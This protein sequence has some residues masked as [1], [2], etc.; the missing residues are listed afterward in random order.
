MCRGERK[1]VTGVCCGCEG[2]RMGAGEEE[3]KGCDM[4]MGVDEC[5]RGNEWRCSEYKWLN[6]DAGGRN[7]KE[8]VLDGV[9]GEMDV[10]G[11]VWMGG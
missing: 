4:W 6:I 7:G 3:V 1:E 2:L 9:N 11:C 8:D 5:N 10:S